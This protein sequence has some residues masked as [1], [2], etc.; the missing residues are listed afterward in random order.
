MMD[1][2]Q[3]N[4]TLQSGLR[5]QCLSNIRWEEFKSTQES[6]YRVLLHL[7]HTFGYPDQS[8]DGNG[9]GVGLNGATGTVL[10]IF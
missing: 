10:V 5:S 3:C 1:R 4:I 2:F 6:M 8:S 9:M 7:N